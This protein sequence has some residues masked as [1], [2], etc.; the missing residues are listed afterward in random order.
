MPSKT[1]FAK[2]QEIVAQK[3]FTITIDLHLGR[4]EYSVFTTDLS[5]DYVRL[6][7]GE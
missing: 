5:T 1:P 4:A 7:M 6:N 3:R 2:L